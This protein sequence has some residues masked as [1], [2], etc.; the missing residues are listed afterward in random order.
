MSQRQVLVHHH[1][2]KNAGTSVDHIL[3]KNFGNTWTEIEGPDSKKL[4]QE[5]LIKHL[6]QSPQIKAISS[7]TAEIV[8][9]NSVDFHLI[10]ILFFRHPIDRIRSAY[11]FERIQNVD[12]P[13]AKMAK[14]GSFN[15]YFEW[16]LSSGSPWQ[17]SNFHAF[18]LKDYF[19]PIS[20]S[21]ADR[22]LPNALD[23]IDSLPVFGL[24]ER[25][26]ESMKLIE[27]YLNKFFPKFKTFS[28]H[29]NRSRRY[30]S[31]G[32]NL[33]EF[34]D[35]IGH[36]TYKRLLEKNYMD[37]SIYDYAKMRFFQRLTSMKA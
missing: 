21:N 15:D 23:V 11:D 37:L 7:H 25:F 12:T 24:V 34:S 5:D 27:L 20:N 32:E 3:K 2:F 17:V 22:F 13:G 1:L 14:T 31:L 26:E 29:E 28:S 16:R 6:N 30:Y 4:T 35:Q 18:R 33:S 10:P 19:E 36:Q 8:P 9:L